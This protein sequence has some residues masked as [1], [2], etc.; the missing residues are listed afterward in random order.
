MIPVIIFYV[1]V[2]FLVYVFT[3]NLIEEGRLS[4]FLSAIFVVI[5]FSVGWTISEFAMSL[6]MESKGLGLFFPRYAFSLLLLTFMEIIF[7][8]FYY[9]GL[10]VKK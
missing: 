9:K 7:Y 3:K 4:A 5:I 2:I 6:F 8:K 1:H 10:R